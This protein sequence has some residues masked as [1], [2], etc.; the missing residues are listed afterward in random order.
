LLKAVAPLFEPGLLF[1]VS[2]KEIGQPDGALCF[3]FFVAG[4][5]FN[6]VYS[7]EQWPTGQP[8]FF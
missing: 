5:L 3:N 8:C 6:F 2:L 7:P 4:V 1:R